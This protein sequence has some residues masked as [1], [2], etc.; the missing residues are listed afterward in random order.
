M[1]W[2]ETTDVEQFLA[3]T[4]D[5]LLPDPGRYT[6]ALTQAETERHR[7][8]RTRF[9]W[10]DAGA[11]EVTGAAMN[12]PPF[13]MLVC[14][15]PDEALPGLLAL[16]RPD[17][18]NGPTALAVQLAALAAGT[19]Q[20]LGAQR[21]F[22]LGTLTS[23]QVPGA[24]R[25][26]EAR[27]RDLVLGWFLAF[28]AEGHPLHVEDDVEAQVDERLA[29][30]SF[31]LWDDDGPKSLAGGRPPAFGAVRVGPVY[32]PPEHRGRGYGGAVTAAVTQ[33]ALDRGASEVVLFTDLTNPTS[34]ALYPRLGYRPL[35]DHAVLRLS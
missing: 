26:A 11:G 24:A 21:L 19:A 25:I 9:A 3:A 12:C 4:A 17:R 1:T 13:P 18:V 23:P 8:G 27:D 10:W 29:Q 20:L 34:N 2:H 15:S 22:R 31:L 5:L 14:T 33:R 7:P 30:E 6:V 16:W 28:M 32:T 35:A